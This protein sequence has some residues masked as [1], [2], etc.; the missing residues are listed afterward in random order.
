MKGD[1]SAVQLAAAGRWISFIV[2][3]ADLEEY[4]ASIHEVAVTITDQREVEIRIRIHG[5]AD[6]PKLVDV[7]ISLG[8]DDLR[9]EL[10]V[11]DDLS[12]T[13]RFTSDRVFKVYEFLEGIVNW[14]SNDSEYLRINDT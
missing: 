10:D 7:Q 11:V 1:S 9:R 3:S 13:E 6:R 4:R 2:S 12:G 14:S 8:V 5:N